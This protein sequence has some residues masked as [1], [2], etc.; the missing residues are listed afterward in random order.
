MQRNEQVLKV[1]LYYKH[2]YA[3]AADAR[4][5]VMSVYEGNLYDTLRCHGFAIHSNMFTITNKLMNYITG[6]WKNNDYNH[7]QL[8]TGFKKDG[9]IKMLTKTSK[10]KP[11][12]QRWVSQASD[13]FSMDINMINEHVQELLEATPFP[14]DMTSL[15]KSWSICALMQIWLYIKRATPTWSLSTAIRETTTR[16]TSC[17]SS[18]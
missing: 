17:A 14:E 4:S 18:G 16:S 10:R 2:V 11:I 12:K 6:R 5:M 15:S 7:Q 8:F 13:T 9:T 1:A 3:P